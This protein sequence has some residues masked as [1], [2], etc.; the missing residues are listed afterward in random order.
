MFNLTDVRFMEK[1]IKT[2]NTQRHLMYINDAEFA[3]TKQQKWWRSNLIIQSGDEE[4]A[5]LKKDSFWKWNFS[6]LKGEEK[7]FSIRPKWNGAIEIHS[8]AGVTWKL[9]KKGGSDNK[10][11]LSNEEGNEV[12]TLEKQGKWWKSRPYKVTLEDKENLPIQDDVLPLI[13]VAALGLLSQR[14]VWI[15]VAVMFFNMLTNQ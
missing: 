4:L 2:K 10:I 11:I 13:I 9:T 8:E 12:M 1:I 6:V 7:L 15:I 3:G 5:L 14:F